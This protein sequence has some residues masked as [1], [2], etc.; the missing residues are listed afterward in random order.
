M[1]VALRI[2]TVAAAIAVLVIVA[3][4]PAQLGGAV[5]DSG[6]GLV[7]VPRGTT[8]LVCPSPPPQ[9]GALGDPQFAG[10]PLTRDVATTVLGV[11]RPGEAADDVQV[12]SA[13]PAGEPQAWPGTASGSLTRAASTTE[14]PTVA[15]ARSAPDGTGGVA[16][17]SSTTIVGG[18]QAGLAVGSC[19][20]PADHGYLVGSATGGTRDG[21]VV[22]TNPGRTV[23]TVDLTVLTPDGPQ[24]PSAGRNLTV[25]PASS[26]ALPLDTLVA[27]QDTLA[28]QVDAKGGQ[29][30]VWLVDT[31]IRGLVPRGIDTIPL[32]QASPV[33][34]ITPVAGPTATLRLVNPGQQAVTARYSIGGPDGPA[35]PQTADLPAG[36]VAD[37]PLT[38]L[39]AQAAVTV[40]ATGPIAAGVQV[41]VE[42]P[43]S[44]PA[45]PEADLAWTSP[46]P[47]LDSRALAAVPWAQNTL[48]VAAEDGQASVTLRQLDAR[49]NAIGG[50]Q[51]VTIPAAGVAAVPVSADAALLQFEVRSGPVHAG[52]L[53]RGGPGNTYL[54]ASVVQAPGSGQESARVTVETRPG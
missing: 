32:T 20:A 19:T 39:P 27:D 1:R 53:S 10:T 35:A 12:S 13:P 44:D 21:R 36:T 34:V 48:V 24:T 6:G 2:L 50:D 4:R 14:E 47:Q 41:S 26:R 51:P 30:G 3:T 46:A 5:A 54:A 8:T 29:V 7:R 11:A 17:V 28:L 15:A 16:A 45:A 33:Q 40:T 31:A 18:D 22:I 9:E 43:G 49:G 42:R 37:V 23:A 52:M 38:G 25:A